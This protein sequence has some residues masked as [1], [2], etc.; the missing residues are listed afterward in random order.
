MSSALGRLRALLGDELFVREGNQ[1]MPTARALELRQPVR[2][3]LAGM[4]EALATTAV[5]DPVTSTRPFVLI[6]SDYFSTLLM[7]PLAARV[8]EAA[9]SVTL[10]MIDHASSEVFEV[11]R[12]G[13]A[14]IV[15]DRSLEPPEWVA[16]RK[17]L[18]SWL[19]CCRK[20]M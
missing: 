3:A 6:G 16:S 8:A 12:D 7:P 18:Q 17:V 20:W 10:Q 19:V 9:P 11:L 1:M 2:K 5:F 13:R 14:D 15:I 4:E